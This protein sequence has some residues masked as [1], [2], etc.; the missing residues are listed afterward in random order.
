MTRCSFHV[1]GFHLST[2]CHLGHFAHPIRRGKWLFSAA[3]LA[4]GWLTMQAS[5]FGCRDC[6]VSRGACFGL[7]SLQL[8]PSPLLPPE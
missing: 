2:T 7:R 1:G 6:T 5:V 8:Q 4:N 3:D